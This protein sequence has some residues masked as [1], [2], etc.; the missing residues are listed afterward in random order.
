MSKQNSPK[1]KQLLG[2]CYKGE[3]ECT[4]TQSEVVMLPRIVITLNKNYKK[5]FE[6]S[7][8]GTQSQY[9]YHSQGFIFFLENSPR[10]HLVTLIS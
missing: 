4:H 2:Q 8:T 5:N 7:L 6:V 3:N 9:K 1:R 10:G